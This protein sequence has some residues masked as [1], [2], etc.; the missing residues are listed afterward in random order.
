MSLHLVLKP[1]DLI[2]IIIGIELMASINETALNSKAWPF[3]EAG[4]LLKRMKKHRSKKEK[5]VFQTGFGPSGLPHIGT[6]GEVARTSMIRH[7]FET[8]SGQPT[9]LIC[10]SDDLDG[11]RKVPDNIPNKEK[12]REDLDLPLCKVRDPF[13]QYQSFA[14]HNNAMLCSFLDRFGFEY[15]F[16]SSAECYQ[17]GMFDEML[18]RTLERFDDV[19]EIMLPSLGGVSRGRTESYSPFLPISPKSGR[20]LQV[21]TLERNPA[22]GTIVYQEPD[23]E[24]LEVSVLGGQVK[25]QWKPDW[26]MRWAALDVDYEMYGKDLIPSAELGLK[27]CRKLG[28]QPPVGMA[29]ELFLDEN[30]QKISKSK[31]TGGVTV[32]E[33]LSCASAESLSTFMYQKPKTAKRLFAEIIPKSMDEY[34][35]HLRA[36]PNQNIDQQLANPAWHIHRGKPPKSTMSLSYSILLNIASASSVEDEESLWGFINS[37][38][39]NLTAE[40]SPD[41][42]NAAKG[43]I[44]YFQTQ[45]LPKREFKIPD[46]KQQQALQEL[47]WRLWFWD[48][49]ID[50]E[51]IQS[52]IYAIGRKHKFEPMRDW[53]RTIYETLFGSSQGPR[54]GGFASVFGVQETAKLIAQRLNSLLPV[55]AKIHAE[56]CQSELYLPALLY[57]ASKEDGQV[58]RS[59]FDE[60]LKQLINSEFRDKAS[61]G[62]ETQLLTTELIETFLNDA[63][64]GLCVQGFA[65]FLDKQEFLRITDK[66]RKYISFD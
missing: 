7:A 16:Y 3:Q 51:T 24:K 5:A 59:D 33:W 54:M 61:S 15:E 32:E 38:E 63:S 56:T 30:G 48:D 31:G 10:F 23:G 34:H 4:Q 66:G 36:F 45:I 43:A 29:Y 65:E 18:I 22:K 44:H 21:P 17:T 13:E 55:E 46:K 57:L 11:F 27:I 26:A 60:R 35:Q 14:A 28:G 50:N 41:L 52:V 47:M 12:M 58:K 1:L 49:K 20:V 40:N 37:Y 2:E 9:Q 6:F 19:M 53:F 62:E 64:T 8:I 25:L 42:A 39:P